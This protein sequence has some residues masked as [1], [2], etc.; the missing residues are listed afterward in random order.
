MPAPLG[1]MKQFVALEK[2]ATL[3]ST[4]I[5]ERRREEIWLFGDLGFIQMSTRM[6]IWKAFP[7]EGLLGP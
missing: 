7:T 1:H 2:K 6:L 4:K 5:L 3:K